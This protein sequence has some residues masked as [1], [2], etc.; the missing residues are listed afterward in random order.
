MVTN[1]LLHLTGHLI[2]N[3]PWAPIG[4]A[5][6]LQGESR[7][8]AKGMPS[9]LKCRPVTQA[10]SWTAGAHAAWERQPSGPSPGSQRSARSQNPCSNA[11]HAHF[12]IRS[13]AWVATAAHIFSHSPFKSLTSSVDLN[14]GKWRNLIEIPI[15]KTKQKPATYWPREATER[16]SRQDF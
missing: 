7:L 10:V 6:P 2:H 13:D 11:R 5:I 12:Q 16:S 4:A 1:L 14:C 9:C 8:H 3:L 15:L